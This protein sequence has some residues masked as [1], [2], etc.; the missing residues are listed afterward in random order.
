M[1]P[2]NSNASAA[3]S[4]RVANADLA[5]EII[6]RLRGVI[7]TP[8]TPLP[9]H[10]P[11]FQGRELE[12]V[13]NCITTGW[14]SSVGRY[15]DRFEEDLAAFTGARHAVAIVNGT[16]A[17]HL[18]LRVVGVQ[19]G[20]EVLVPALSFVA[21][22][23]AIAHLGAVPHF[24][25]S[26]LGTLGMDPDKLADHLAE[27]VEVRGGRCVNRRTGR[28]VAAIVPMH[29]FGHSVRLGPLLEVSR[30]YRLPVV[31]DAAESLGSFYA[32]RH[33]GIWGRLGVLSFNGNKTITTGGGGAIITDDDE[34]ARRAKHLS[35]TA[36]QPHA[37][38]FV[39][40]EVGFNYR[41]PNLNAALGCAQLEQ[42][43]AF[44][45]RKRLLAEAY[46]RAFADLAGVRFVTEPPQ[47]RSNFWL[48]ALELRGGNSDLL[49]AVLAATNAAH[50][51]TRPAWRLLSELPMY[52]GCPAGDL[53]VA[54]RLAGSL[55][56]IPSSPGLL[57]Q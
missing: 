4:A 39:H 36:K 14:V 56:N 55:L 49:Q 2:H 41:M 19:P 27:T 42:L 50:F 35:T 3:S 18:A 9:L 6:A 53:T 48:C 51:G 31:E 1:T 43:P 45:Q 17:L 7:G 21:T 28:P 32:G 16:C 34:L 38:E 40:D 22:A 33:T 29:T 20:E 37:W 52:Q 30:H 5:G 54:R 10:A 24:V 8:K 26:E 46:E 25:D 12:Y 13:S 47:S 44:L 15:V 11:C 57:P 23:N